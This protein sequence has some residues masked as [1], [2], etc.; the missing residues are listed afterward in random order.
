MRFNIKNSRNDVVYKGTYALVGEGVVWS[1]ELSPGEV[2]RFKVKGEKHSSSKVKTL[3]AVDIEK[4]NNINEFVNYVVTE[5]RLNQGIEQVF[6]STGRGLDI[7]LTGE[8]VKWVTSDIAKEEIDTLVGNGL[9]FKDV[10]GN[11]SKKVASWFK[12]YLDK[13]L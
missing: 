3:A 2:V 1:A 5:N 4:L 10:M 6:T 13:N 8:F 7:K 9:E 11:C 12:S